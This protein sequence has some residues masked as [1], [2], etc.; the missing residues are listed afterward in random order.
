MTA[1]RTL[2]GTDGVRGVVGEG[3]TNEL[4]ERLGRAFVVFAGGG[5]VLIGQ[6]TRS[7]GEAIA[8]ALAEGI[9]SAGGRAAIGGVLPTAA[10][11]LLADELGA[12]VSASHNPAEYNGIKFFRHGGRKLSDGDELAVEALLDT[13]PQPGGSIGATDGLLAEYRMMISQRFGTALDGLRIVCDCAN[14]ALSQVAPGLLEEL[15]AEVTAIGDAPDGHNINAGCGATEPELLQRTVRAGEFD[16]GVAFDGDGDRLLACDHA[17]QLVDGDQIV[18]ILALHLGVELVA[19]TKVTNAGFHEL[20]DQRGIR[21]ITT[22]VGDRYVLEALEGEGGTLG[23][24]QSGHVIVRDRHVTGDGLAACLLLGG[25]L[26]ESGQ[27][28]RDAAAVMPKWEQ[29]SSSVPVTTK[30]LPETLVREIER[31]NG[32]HRGQARLLVRPSGTEPVVR[33]LAEA[34]E[35][36]AAIDLHRNGV[37]LVQDELG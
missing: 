34:R 33:V 17:G 26:M 1:E 9:A 23:G 4:A 11:A 32:T 22:D 27:T 25:A 18:A 10:V 20:M 29:V 24:E 6:D 19:V 15:G 5:E 14:G 16:L 30:T 13:A 36:A 2:F 12:V 31:L 28:L 8:R 35:R 37:R 7:S 3:M 21:V